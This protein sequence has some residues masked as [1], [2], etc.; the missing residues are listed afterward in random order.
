MSNNTVFPLNNGIILTISQIIKDVMSSAA[1]A[2]LGALYIA[3]CKASYI[4]IIIKEL[5]HEHPKNSIQTDNSTAEGFINRN[6]TQTNQS[7]G[8]VI[9]LVK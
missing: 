1:K 8:H 9:L 2:E 4:Q 7:H 6:T 3:A 5:V